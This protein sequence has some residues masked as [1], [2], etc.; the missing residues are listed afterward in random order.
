MLGHG[1]MAMTPKC[2]GH[3]VLDAGAA[4]DPELLRELLGLDH[5][6]GL[7]GSALDPGLLRVLAAAGG[8]LRVEERLLGD[9]EALERLRLDPRRPAACSSRRGRP[10][11]RPGPGFELLVARLLRA[12]AA[13]RSCRASW[14]RAPP[15]RR[16]VLRRGGLGRAP[17]CRAAP[18]SR[19]GGRAATAATGEAAARRRGAARSPSSLQATHLTRPSDRLEEVQPQA[20][21]QPLDL[22]VQ[23]EELVVKTRTPI[24]IRTTPETTWIAT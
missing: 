5:G 14:C 18:W 16:G 15:R 7:L 1:P 22:D 10:P 24:T 4:D 12:S 9:E 11:G 3:R 8:G 17:R 2:A 20:L 21:E 23:P 6:L 19:V 13:S